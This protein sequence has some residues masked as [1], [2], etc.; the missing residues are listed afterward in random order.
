MVVVLVQD[1][2]TSVA[3]NGID[4]ARSG[5]VGA[6]LSVLLSIVERREECFSWVSL[7]CMKLLANQ[8][9]PT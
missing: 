6:T 1:V 8:R 2:C 5:D 7:L 4:E 3:N 9:V